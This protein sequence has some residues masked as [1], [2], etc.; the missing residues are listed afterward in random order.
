MYYRLHG[1]LV[2]QQTFLHWFSIMRY[3]LIH[4]ILRPVP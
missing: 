2:V 4:L 1:M 3:G